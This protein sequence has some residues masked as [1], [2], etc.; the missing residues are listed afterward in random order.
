M[1]LSAISRWGPVTSELDVVHEARVMEKALL[2]YSRQ[3]CLQD[4]DAGPTDQLLDEAAKVNLVE[5]ANGYYVDLE[6]LGFDAQ[7]VMLPLSDTIE[8]NTSINTGL[9]W[10]LAGWAGSSAIVEVSASSP[11]P[12]N[13]LKRIYPFSNEISTNHVRFLMS[14][15]ASQTSHAGYGFLREEVFLDD[16]Q[17][18]VYMME[19]GTQ[20]YSPTKL[21][22]IL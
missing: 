20:A 6:D 12:I 14:A 11:E 10:Q 2:A 16:S 8:N 19:N 1:T 22:C 3:A 9:V 7:V 17:H 13:L 15:D 5:L 21:S 4:T 18:P